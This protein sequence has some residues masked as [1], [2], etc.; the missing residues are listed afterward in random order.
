MII[1]Y[2]IFCYCIG[3]GVRFFFLE[4]L[5]RKLLNGIM[6]IYLSKPVNPYFF[7]AIQ[8]FR[9]A[10]AL[11]YPLLL[12]IILIM[13][14]SLDYT[15]YFLGLIMMIFGVA[16]YMIFFN[17]FSSIS[18]F[19]K[20]DGMIT[21]T[22]SRDINFFIE[23]YTP[24]LFYKMKFYEIIY[25]FPSSFFG[26]LTIIVFK[27]NL[28]DFNLFLPIVLISFII[29]GI[30]NYLLWHYGLKKYEVYG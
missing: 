26:Y 27:G 19:I 18:F 5:S 29:M 20:E 23:D 15:N 21:Q 1:Y 3:K 4:G 25:L 30:G 8:K 6:N 16:Y 28:L 11:T 17:F 7:S 12:L 24:K 10:N 9:G 14:F 2:I 22:F 13:I